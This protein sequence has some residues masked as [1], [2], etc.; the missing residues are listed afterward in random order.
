TIE[1]QNGEAPMQFKASETKQTPADN[2]SIFCE[3]VCRSP[4]HHRQSRRQRITSVYFARPFTE[5]QSII[6]EAE[7]GATIVFQNGDI[8]IHLHLDSVFC[9]LSTAVYAIK[10][11]RL[12]LKY[13]R[14]G[15][16][17]EAGMQTKCERPRK[18]Y[19]CYQAWSA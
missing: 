4:R 5:V 15:A 13:Y 8:C 18:I 1:I 12:R 14:G 7:S 19:C 17:C 6:S 16:K 9:C 3:T 11:E 2:I 10:C